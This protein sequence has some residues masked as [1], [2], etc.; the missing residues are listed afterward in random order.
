MW[1]FLLLVILVMISYT[2]SIIKIFKN[3]SSETVSLEGNLI[4]MVVSI[5]L[6]SMADSK[7]IEYINIIQLAFLL[8]LNATIIYYWKDRLG[9]LKKIIVGAGGNRS[10]KMGIFGSMVGIYGIAQSIKCAENKTEKTEVSMIMYVT[11]ILYG[12]IIL[13]LATSWLVIVAEVMSI[14]AYLYIVYRIYN[15]TKPKVN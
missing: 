1:L 12:F 9:N 6:Y 13:I 2:G 8:F 10:L 11:S 5:V 7:Y 14:I 15:K 4:A 3:K